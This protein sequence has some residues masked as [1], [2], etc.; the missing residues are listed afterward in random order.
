MR[1]RLSPS[2]AALMEVGILFLPAIL[3]YL[4][5]WPNM[6]GTTGEVVQ[7]LVYLYVLAGRTLIIL[8]VNWGVP[9]P[10]ASDPLRLTW[11]I[12]FYFAL[13]GLVEELLFRGL[14]YCALVEWRGAAWAICGTSVGFVLWHIFGQGPLVGLAGLIYG[15]IFALIRWRAGG[16]LGLILVHGLIDIT[17]VHMLPEAPFAQQPQ[18]ASPWLIAAGYALLLAVPVYLWWRASTPGAGIDHLR[19]TT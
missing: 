7:S 18:V 5:L 2:V 3:A 15:I 10:S 6:H 14:L 12:L 11:E 9:L 8:G 16:I 1:T 13:V 19:H 17:A 4:W